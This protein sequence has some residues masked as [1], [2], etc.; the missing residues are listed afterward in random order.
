LTDIVRVADEYYVRASSA[1][2]DDRTRVLKSGDTFLIA[3]RYGDIE[4]LGASQFGLFHAESRHLSRFSMRLNRL[5]PLLLSSVVR[6]DNLFLAIDLTNVDSPESATSSIGDL[7]RGIVHLFRSQFLLNGCRYE[8]IRIRNYGLESVRLVLSFQFDA[9]FADIFEVRGSKRQRRG[10]RLSPRVEGDAVV[11]AYQGLDDLHRRTRIEFSPRPTAL[12]ADEASYSISLAP[13]EETS[14]FGSVSC[15]RDNS[16]VHI[17]SYETAFLNAESEIKQA[18]E[19]ACCVGSSS[20]TLDKWLHRSSADI[21]M[22]TL[23]NPEGP[24]PYAVYRGSVPYSAAMESSL[25]FS[26]CGLSRE[27]Q[28]AF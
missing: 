26:A 4:H 21:R 27:W 17:A 8:H 6:E 3:N 15:L 5:Q 22:L 9:D 16:D 23:H 20:E 1:L 19:S 24:Y 13:A 11:L 7:S 28:R 18:E 2:A 14:I 12:G 25:P 10:K